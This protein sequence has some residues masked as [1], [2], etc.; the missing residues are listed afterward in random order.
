MLLYIARA[1]IAGVRA[2]LVMVQ[3]ASP[4]LRMMSLITCK[5]A[6]FTVDESALGPNTICGSCAVESAG[7]GVVGGMSF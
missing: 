2:V 4:A 6:G 7:F 3:L 1:C 5:A